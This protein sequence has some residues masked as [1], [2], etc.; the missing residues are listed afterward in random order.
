MSLSGTAGSHPLST[1]NRVD[2]ALPVGT[3]SPASHSSLPAAT[4]SY[5]LQTG[6]QQHRLVARSPQYG[7]YDSRGPR[8]PYDAGYPASGP[9]RD[10]RPRDRP[11]RDDRPRDRPYRDDRP[12]DRP[13][14]DER[15]YR[16]DRPRGGGDGA[17]RN[18]FDDDRQARQEREARRE[19]AREREMRDRDR[20]YRGATIIAPISPVSVV[21]YRPTYPV[22][23]TQRP[24]Y[25]VV[26]PRPTYPVVVPRPTYPVVVS[27]RPAYPLTQI[28]PTQPRTVYSVRPQPVIVTVPGTPVTVWEPPVTVSVPGPAVTV[29][30]PAVPVTVTQL[31]PGNEGPSGLETIDSEVQCRQ[32][33]DL[34]ST[35]FTEVTTIPRRSKVSVDC[36]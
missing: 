19:R 12:R 14:R 23:V 18:G 11:Y 31:V 10:D 16:G 22:V 25:P 20:N 1:P 24:T 7:S 35:Q 8:G 33:P 17:Y 26:V 32:Y 21:P 6:H 29:S 34:V 2:N 13:Y 9:Y 30:V 27:P 3:A 4:G 36:W 15:G 28:V 5:Q